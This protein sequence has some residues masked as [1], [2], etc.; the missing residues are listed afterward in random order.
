MVFG[1]SLG[2]WKYGVSR[3]SDGIWWFVLGFWKY[4]VSRVSD[5]IWWFVSVLEIW[6][7]EG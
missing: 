4:G 5:G 7:F 3:V 1:G 2:F 6:G